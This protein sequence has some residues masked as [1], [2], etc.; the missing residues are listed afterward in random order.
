LYDRITQNCSKKC[1]AQ[2]NENDLNVGEMACVD[3][4]VSKYLQTH[5]KVGEVLNNFEKQL[6]EQEKGGK[7][8]PKFANKL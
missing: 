4:C 6:L 2:F 7:S 1:V 8:Q 3:R 5:E